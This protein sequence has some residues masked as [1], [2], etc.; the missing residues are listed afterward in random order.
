MGMRRLDEVVVLLS[1]PVRRR[2]A[3]LHDTQRL[4][5]DFTARLRREAKR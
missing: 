1:P 4:A 5:E 2:A 3:L